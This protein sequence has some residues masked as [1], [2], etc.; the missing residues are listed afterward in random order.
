MTN[1]K[2]VKNLFERTLELKFTSNKA[3]F[4]NNLV[5]AMYK[6]K[7]RIKILSL[8]QFGTFNPAY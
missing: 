4:Y 3:H 2:F 5:Y 1:Y 6:S 8:Q 7:Y